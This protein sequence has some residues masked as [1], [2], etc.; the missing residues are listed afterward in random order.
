ML[1]HPF[2]GPGAGMHTIEKRTSER[3]PFRCDIQ[4]EAGGQTFPAQGLNI[5]EGGVS[6]VTNAPVSIGAAKGS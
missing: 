6:F 1:T 5:S 4:V 2:P 3:R